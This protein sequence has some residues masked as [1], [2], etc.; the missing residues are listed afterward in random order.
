MTDAVRND[1]VTA[2]LVVAAGAKGSIIEGIGFV[3]VVAVIA[4]YLAPVVG[5]AMKARQE[6]IAKQ[7]ADAE[8]AGM[9]LAEAQAAYD[10][11]IAKAKA[12]AAEMLA[13]ARSQHASIVAEAAGAARAR[14]EEITAR[15]RETLEAERLQAVKS[16]QAEIAALAVEQAE[17]SVH[18]SLAD[19]ARQRRVID[20][21]LTE[22]E[23]GRVASGETTSTGGRSV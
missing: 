18:A 16:L 3:I 1:A 4:R 7:L 5:K 22:L 12:E 9:K 10:A 11:A 14:A 21:F 19:D 6:V 17:Q 2:D 8:S 15:A 20:R 13:D 23:S